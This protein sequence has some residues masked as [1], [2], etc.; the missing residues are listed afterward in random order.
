MTSVESLARPMIIGW[1]VRSIL[2]PARGPLTITRE[3]G[4]LR[5]LRAG[6]AGL[7]RPASRPRA[8]LR[9]LL[10]AGPNRSVRITPTAMMMNSHSTARNASLI[11]KRVN[12]DIAVLFSPC[13][14][15][16]GSA[17]MAPPAHAVALN[18]V[19]R[20]GSQVNPLDPVIVPD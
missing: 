4:S 18:R 12:S 7:G 13:R 19:Y 15:P 6:R 5:R 10:V 8:E 17:V 9:F 20:L 11:N 14:A 1:E 3:Q 16:A 2:V